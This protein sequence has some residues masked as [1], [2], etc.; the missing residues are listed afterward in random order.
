MSGRTSV[1]VAATVATGMGA[2]ALLPTY[3]DLH[4]LPVT[5]G[6]VLVVGV[7]AQGARLVGVPSWLSPFVALAALAGYVTAVFAHTTA[8]LGFLPGSAARSV[9]ADLTRHGWHDIAVQRAPVPSGQ[10]LV[11]LT[12]CGVGLVAVAVDF[13]A[14]VVRRPSL[15][16]LPL[17]ALFAVSASTVPHGV[18]WLPFVYAGFGYLL[19]LLAE[20]ADRI[21]RWGHPLG[22]GSPLAAEPATRVER[23][24]TGPIVQVGRRVGFA[25]IA[26]AVVVPALIPGLH[27]GIFGSNPGHGPGFGNGGSTVTTYNPIL[28]IRDQ[29]K[30][31]DHQTLLRYATNDPDP[32]YLRMTA[33]DRYVGTGWTQGDL[34]APTSHQVTKGLPAPPGLTNTIVTL[35]A[36]SNIEATQSLEVPWLPVPYPSV[37]ISVDKGDWRWDELSGAIF[38]TQT[39]TRGH[40]WAVTSERL[41]PTRAQLRTA[42]TAHPATVDRDLEIDAVRLPPYIIEKAQEVTKH[43]RTPF[44]KA[45]ALQDYF[46]SSHFTYSLDPPNNDGTDAVVAFLKDGRGY[47]VQFA[48]SMALMARVLEIPSRVAIGFTRGTQ[49]SDGS[50]VVTTA[51]AHAWPELYFEGVGWVPFEPTPR[52]DGQAEQPLYTQA[53]PTAPTPSQ[54][55]NAAGVTP[56]PTPSSTTPLSPE[57]RRALNEPTPVTFK[58][59][60]HNDPWTG[61]LLGLLVLLV[62]LAAPSLGRALT[63]RRRWAGAETDAARAHVAWQELIDDASDLG[64]EWVA[65]DSSRPAGSPGRSMTWPS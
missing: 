62:L 36:K 18:G 26:V 55:P 50:Y 21:S 61:V 7:V 42:S 20:G 17:L 22:A 30:S 25:A 56:T 60:N 49:Q 41:Q 1:A 14:M 52:G 9:L 19:L 4:W 12:V 51:D 33:L 15:A 40:K 45:L 32:A 6:A 39:T 53:T 57:L 28:K 34:T 31:P 10:S 29:L 46:H 38:S 3:A 54:G 27:S 13:I 23:A 35:S 8:V 24:Q 63:R 37:S 43:A 65:A 2:L 16:G 11:L 59:H 48:A 47:C 58:S 5:W 44:E 64:F